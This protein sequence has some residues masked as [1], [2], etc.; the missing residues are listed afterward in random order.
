MHV[1]SFLCSFPH[2]SPIFR[3]Q[4]IYLYFADESIIVRELPAFSVN[5]FIAAF[6]FHAKKRKTYTRE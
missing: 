3:E 1:I 2:S 6:D 4:T 5:K